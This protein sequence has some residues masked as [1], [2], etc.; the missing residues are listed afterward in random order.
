MCACVRARVSVCACVCER[1][2]A[3]AR[4]RIWPPILFLGGARQADALVM[5]GAGALIA[6]HEL[7]AVKTDATVILRLLR[8]VQELLTHFCHHRQLTTACVRAQQ[9]TARWIY[10]ARMQRLLW[11]RRLWHRRL[12]HRRLWHRRLPAR[13]LHTDRPCTRM[14]AN[15]QGAAQS[16]RLQH[17]CNSTCNSPDS[18]RRPTHVV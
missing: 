7:A 18:Y 3:R 15:G 2:R 10:Y 4:A 8:V 14:H 13:Y 6:A 5:N 17:D 9:T 16:L 1:E 12:W 11:H